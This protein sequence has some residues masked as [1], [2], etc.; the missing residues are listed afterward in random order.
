MY[1]PD[2]SGES[3]GNFRLKTVE[4]ARGALHLHLDV[5]ARLITNI[6]G[7]LVVRCYR[8]CRVAET[9]TLYIPGEDNF[10]TFHQS[11]SLAI[12][13][14]GV[15]NITP[16]LQS[17]YPWAQIRRRV[18]KSHQLGKKPWMKHGLNTEGK[19]FYNHLSCFTHIHP[20]FICVQSVANH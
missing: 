8:M 7:N 1:R 2:V 13:F 14:A 10:P 4:F 9:N 18:A 17:S 16:P 11:F 20:C 3:I 15:P 19:G 12:N 6:A 5:A